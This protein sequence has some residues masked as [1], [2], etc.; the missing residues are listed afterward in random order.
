MNSK[1]SATVTIRSVMMTK[2]FKAGFI[3]FREGLPLKCEFSRDTN[4]QWAYE[5][6]R[7]FAAIYDGATYKAGNRVTF[8]AALAMHHAILDKVI[9]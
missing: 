5:R 9:L 2:A 7:L 8:H 4:T 6:G 3:S 1:K